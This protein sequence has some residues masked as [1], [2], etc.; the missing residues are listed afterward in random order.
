MKIATAIQKST[1]KHEGP[2]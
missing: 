1:V 2:V